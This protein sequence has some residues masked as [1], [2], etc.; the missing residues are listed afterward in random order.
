MVL[1]FLVFSIPQQNIMYWNS[2]VNAPIP[3]TYPYTLRKSW[4]LTLPGGEVSYCLAVGAGGGCFPSR[5]KLFSGL[6]QSQELSLSYL[7]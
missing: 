6:T 2:S 1:R 4:D 5:S 7:I 3:G